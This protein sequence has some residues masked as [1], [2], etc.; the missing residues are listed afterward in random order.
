[1]SLAGRGAYVL[2]GEEARSV[3][4]GSFGAPQLE[5]L[6]L[7]HGQYPRVAVGLSYM[8]LA[9]YAARHAPEPLYIIAVLKLLKGWLGAFDASGIFYSAIRRDMHDVVYFMVESGARP[10]EDHVAYALRRDEEGLA[11]YLAERGGVDATTFK[12]RPRGGGVRG[13]E[14]L[15]LAAARFP[16]LHAVLMKLQARFE[17]ERVEWEASPECRVLKDKLARELEA[18]GRVRPS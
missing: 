7:D 18:A 15:E 8:G 4:D 14:L 5:Q 12:P 3:A 10:C 6:I 1:M 11:C 9:A 13:N 2:T 16:L 17:R